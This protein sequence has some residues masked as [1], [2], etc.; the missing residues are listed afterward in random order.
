ME[1]HT[2]AP[3]TTTIKRMFLLGCALKLRIMAKIGIKELCEMMLIY[4][5]C[6][7]KAKSAASCI[8]NVFLKAPSYR[9]HHLKSCRTFKG[10]ALRD[11]PRPLVRRPR[12]V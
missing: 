4:G 12:N 7:R 6:G 10:E 8:V 1:R 2:C 9:A 3:E 11:Q 5:E